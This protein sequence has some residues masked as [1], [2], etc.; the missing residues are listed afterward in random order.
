MSEEAGAKSKKGGKMPLIVVLVAVVGAG[1]FFGMKMK[2]GPAKKPEVKLSAE[3][4]VDFKEFLVNL[5]DRGVYC[6]AE[7]SLGTAE[8]ADAKAIADHTAAI[9]DVINLRLA[10]KTLDQVSTL[11][12]LKLLKREIAFDANTALLGFDP[13]GA[14]ALKALKNPDDPKT[15]FDKSDWD[16]DTGPVLEVY[17]D[18]FV[19]Q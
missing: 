2:S 6:R 3:P 8:G 14:D 17:F 11:A 7:I 16:S 12:G 18:S 1:G 5:K 4:A 13:K 10:S 9:R 19:T 15:K